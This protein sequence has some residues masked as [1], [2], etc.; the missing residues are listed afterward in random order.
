MK[1][2]RPNIRLLVVLGVLLLIITIGQS[3]LE[4]RSS[5]AAVLNL[6]SN[7]A[8]ALITSVAKAGEK[9]LIA[10]HSLQRQI[11]E[12]IYAIAGYIDIL[13]QKGQLNRDE[14]EN[15]IEYV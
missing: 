2:F 12:R 15:I 9:G 11:K 13:Y 4:Y 8:K 10:Y 7:Q 5:R 3:Y 6:F 14:L 1:V